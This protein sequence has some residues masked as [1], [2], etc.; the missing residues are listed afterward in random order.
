[1]VWS[2]AASTANSGA[3]RRN[4]IDGEGAMR[5]SSYCQ[6]ELIVAADVLGPDES[7][8]GERHAVLGGRREA[9][10]EG[11]MWPF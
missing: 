8:G 7:E 4:P 6:D 9:V 10:R 11:K 5:L 1:L 3:G 2:T